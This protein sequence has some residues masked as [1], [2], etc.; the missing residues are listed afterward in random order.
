M[1]GKGA[2]PY[3]VDPNP[4]GDLGLIQP[5]GWSQCRSRRRYVLIRASQLGICATAPV[6]HWLMVAPLRM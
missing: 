1:E 6:G 2:E 4:I 3:T 5:G